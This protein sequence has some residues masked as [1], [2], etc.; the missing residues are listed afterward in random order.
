[1]TTETTKEL[2]EMLKFA[3]S[4]DWGKQAIVPAACE[5]LHVY[6]NYLKKIV[7]FYDLKTLKMWAGY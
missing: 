7:K 1:M 4:H 2:A 3:N 6:D 5:A